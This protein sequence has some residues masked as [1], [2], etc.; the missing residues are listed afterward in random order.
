MSGSETRMYGVKV[1]TLLDVDM[2]LK[3]R[4]KR[5][6]TCSCKVV[7]GNGKCIVVVV[8]SSSVKLRLLSL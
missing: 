8:Y 6:L 3:S 4:I 1:L 2:R 5:S 7:C